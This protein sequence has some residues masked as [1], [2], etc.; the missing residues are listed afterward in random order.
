MRKEGEK[1][2]EGMNKRDEKQSL[3]R[4][5]RNWEREDKRR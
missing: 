4:D 1:R 2:D 3:E 5:Y